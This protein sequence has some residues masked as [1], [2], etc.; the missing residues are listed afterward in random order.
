MVQHP[1]Q[2]VDGVGSKR[3]PYLGAVE[4]HSHH[5]GVD[6]PVIGDVGELEPVH[7]AP[8]QWIEQLGDGHGGS[9]GSRHPGDGD[10]AVQLPA[11]PR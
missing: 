8:C 1:V 3:V 4:G 10:E 11:V 7:L 9:L 6:R 2:L 5:A